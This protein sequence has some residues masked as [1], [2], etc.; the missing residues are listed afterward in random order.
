MYR[1]IIFYIITIFKIA[2]D[3]FAI[4][5]FLSVPDSMFMNEFNVVGLNQK[6][7]LFEIV[8]ILTSLV[9]YIIWRLIYKDSKYEIFLSV[10]GAVLNISYVVVICFRFLRLS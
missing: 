6:L 5:M 9:Y 8:I 10:I 2:F 1:K 7:M 3:V 4:I